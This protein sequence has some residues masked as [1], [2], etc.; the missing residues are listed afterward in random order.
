MWGKNLISRI[1]HTDITQLAEE[2][3]KL[4]VS[5]RATIRWWPPACSRSLLPFFRW[6]SDEWNSSTCNPPN[7]EP[8]EG[9]SNPFPLEKDLPLLPSSQAKKKESQFRLWMVEQSI[10][11]Q[12]PTYD[13]YFWSLYVGGLLVF[14]YLTF[15]H[16]IYDMD[17]WKLKNVIPSVFLGYCSQADLGFLKLSSTFWNWANL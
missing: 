1:N 15:F 5:R 8:L 12:I 11:C 9:R 7:N 6:A 4:R 17:I 16:H 10:N 14:I 2:S 13:I 3:W